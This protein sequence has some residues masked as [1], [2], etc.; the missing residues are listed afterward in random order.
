MDGK[1]DTLDEF[2]DAIDVWREVGLTGDD[3]W[4]MTTSKGDVARRSD[5]RKFDR[6]NGS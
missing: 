5:V 1:N 2:I 3:V 4:C 6:M